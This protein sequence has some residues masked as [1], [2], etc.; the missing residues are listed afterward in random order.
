MPIELNTPDSLQYQFYPF[1]NKIFQFRVRAANDAHIV[2]SREPN[3][4]H[5]IIEVFIG[6]WKNSKS[7][8]QKNQAKREVA[9]ALTPGILNA[10]ELRGFWIRY[11]VGA[12]TVGHEGEED[13]F[14]T[15]YDL[16]PFIA[17]YVGVCTGW[18]A[19]GT[20]V[21]D[22]QGQ[23]NDQSSS[24]RTGWGATG[25]WVSDNNQ[26]QQ[27]HQSSS[28]AVQPSPCWVSA[29]NGHVPPDAVEGGIDD[30]EPVFV[31]R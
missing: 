27:N 12:V 30:G 26:G 6:G 5:P 24:V 16:M 11:T 7:I 3:D 31:A 2:L 4:T 20:W 21:I 1:H 22:D 8:I 29:S 19:T 10:N 14:L 9:E 17:N 15:W 18:G 28:V 13:A 23:Q 25:K